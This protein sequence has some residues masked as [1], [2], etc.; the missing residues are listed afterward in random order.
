MAL[1]AKA[2]LAALGLLVAGA[3]SASATTV[4]ARINVDN[5][6]DIFLTTD[7]GV[8][9]ASLGSAENWRVTS[10]FTFALT[11]GVTNY[12]LIEA[13]DLG[14]PQAMLGEFS[15]SDALFRFDNDGQYMLTGDAGVTVN[16]TGFGDPFGA[17]VDLGA[18][19]GAGLPWT[20]ANGGSAIA[21]MPLSAEW[22]WAPGGNVSDL[23]PGAPREFTYFSIAITPIPGPFGAALLVSALGV[24]AAVRRRR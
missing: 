1:Y 6:F 5:G 9:G 4:T 21:G 2:S 8:P 7:P 20:N 14:G 3:T 10:S 24:A 17:T 11:P 12:L 19:G 16:T 15:L 22:V 13:Y 18:N 23:P